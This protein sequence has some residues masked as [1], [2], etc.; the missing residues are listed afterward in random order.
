MKCIDW[1]EFQII[2]ITYSGIIVTEILFINL[3]VAEL[4]LKLLVL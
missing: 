1:F 4:Q 2:Y 3:L